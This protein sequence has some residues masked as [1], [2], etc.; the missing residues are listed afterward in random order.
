MKAVRAGWAAAMIVLAV[1]ATSR[2]LDLP[3]ALRDVSTANPTLAARSAM[4]DAA[5]GRAGAAGSWFAPRFEAGVINV[6]TKGGFD[7]D[8]MTMKM[9]GVTQRLPVFGPQ[10]LAHDAA[11]E[12]VTR[13]IASGALTNYELLAMA[14]EAY[15]DAR[16]GGDLA[17][18]AEQHGELMER[19]VAAAR[20]R[21]ES[22]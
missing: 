16:L 13:E 3:G 19:L 21:Y 6:P 8:P 15:A 4:V 10:G 14:W 9:I 18:I 17:R 7:A 5:R 22:G 11:R 20:A 1:P 12:D 2:A